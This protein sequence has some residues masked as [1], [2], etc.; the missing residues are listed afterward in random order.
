MTET[1]LKQIRQRMEDGFAAWYP[2]D[3]SA[4]LE[5]VERLRLTAPEGKKGQE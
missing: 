2:H 4:L 1:E 3:V 5:E